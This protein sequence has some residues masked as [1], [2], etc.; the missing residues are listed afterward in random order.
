MR[1]IDA[2]FLAAIASDTYYAGY[3][4]KVT[5]APEWG[6]ARYWRWT[7]IP[8]GV[9]IDGES[10]TSRPLVIDGAPQYG[11]AALGDM[12]VCVSDT[13]LAL[14][15]EVR[16]DPARLRWREIQVFEL[17]KKLPTDPWVHDTI[18]L[19]GIQTPNPKDGWC[20][21][22]IGADY[23]PWARKIPEA[24]TA[25]CRY[26]D[27]VICEH[28]GTCVQTKDACSANG[29]LSINGGFQYLPAPG[30]PII[31]RDSSVTVG[32]GEGA[33]RAAQRAR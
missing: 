7:S 29:H 31:F 15:T 27:T 23:P 28:V 3:A 21:L 26:R 4:I 14:Q 10:Y 17:V 6:V 25:R 8:G 2:A 32:G 19:G 9:T 5:L 33:G 12:S 16:N 13:D 24:I 22:K 30:T 18:F 1:T 11:N 20:W